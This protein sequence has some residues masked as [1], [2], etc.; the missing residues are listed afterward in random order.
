MEFVSITLWILSAI[1]AVMGCLDQSK[2]YWKFDAPRY[3][4][5]EANEP[6]DRA[7]ATERAGMFAAAAFFA[8]FGFFFFFFFAA[9]PYSA[10]EVREVAEHV[11]AEA[12]RDPDDLLYSLR[13]EVNALDRGALS[14]THLSDHRYELTNNG[15]EFRV[16]LS[17]RPATSDR[18]ADVTV[19]DGRCP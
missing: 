2:L 14:V 9:G 16:C 8:G 13:R 18:P 11:A 5:P 17:A 1:L 19:T 3:R 10:S 4:H 12:R 6:S 15:G 7:Y